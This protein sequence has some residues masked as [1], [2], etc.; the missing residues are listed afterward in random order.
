MWMNHP[1]NKDSFHYYMEFQPWVRIFTRN[2]WYFSYY[3]WG[4]AGPWEKAYE[5]MDRLGLITRR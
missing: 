2:T 1:V 5:A 3:L 4:A